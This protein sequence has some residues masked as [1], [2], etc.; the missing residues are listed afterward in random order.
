VLL[1]FVICVVCLKEF[2]FLSLSLLERVLVCF[3]SLSL[4][5]GVLVSLSGLCVLSTLYIISRHNM[6]TQ[7]LCTQ[8]HKNRWTPTKEK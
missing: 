3:L 2:L 6:L 5:E 8:K 4:L 1:L 7:I